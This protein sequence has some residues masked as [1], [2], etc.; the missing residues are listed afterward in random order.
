MTESKWP[1]HII[2][3]RQLFAGFKSLAGLVEVRTSEG[4]D[5]VERKGIMGCSNSTVLR[6]SGVSQ[7]V[8]QGQFSIKG[9]AR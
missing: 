5:F 3:S 7:I 8:P 1:I 2:G 9:C 6:N 4:E